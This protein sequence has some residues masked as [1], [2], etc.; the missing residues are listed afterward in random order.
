MP[1]GKLSPVAKVVT[2]KSFELTPGPCT[3]KGWAV[4][5]RQLQ[6]IAAVTIKNGQIEQRQKFQARKIANSLFNLC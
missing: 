3:V 2:R 5:T 6:E 4:A 1:I